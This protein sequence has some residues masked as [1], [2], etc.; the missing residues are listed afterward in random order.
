MKVYTVYKH[1]NKI[2]NKVYIG[3]TSMSPP[4]KRWNN[5]YGYYHNLHFDSAIKKYGWSNFEHEILFEQLSKEEA[6]QKEIELIKYYN[7]CNS[8]YGYNIA[9]GGLTGIAFHSDESKEKMSI[10]K[11]GEKNPMFGKHHTEETKEKIRQR[12]IGRKASQ[13]TIEKLRKCRKNAK[14]VRCIETQQEFISIAEAA[15]WLNQKSPSTIAGCCNGLY[16]TA[17]GYH[18]EWIDNV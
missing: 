6:E 4:S 14:P 18:W 15:R 7:S 10:N 17:G 5:G 13:E 12:A 8:N 16:L 3:I 11:S 9:T 2:N 1:T